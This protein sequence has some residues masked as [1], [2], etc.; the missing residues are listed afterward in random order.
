MKTTSIDGEDFSNLLKAIRSLE[1]LS[2][3]YKLI[4]VL[5]DS[6]LEKDADSVEVQRQLF[7]VLYEGAVSDDALRFIFLKWVGRS[8]NVFASA[9]KAGFRDGRS[10]ANLSRVRQAANGRKL[11]GSATREKVR[12]SAKNY[13]HLAKD[14]AAHAIAT[15]IG[16]SSGRVRKLLAQLFPGN[17]WGTG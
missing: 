14:D 2:D 11:I 13:M 16:K 7:E 3:L 6:L 5:I 9:Y 1:S 4:D 12:T 17:E 10:Q 8:Q 15:D